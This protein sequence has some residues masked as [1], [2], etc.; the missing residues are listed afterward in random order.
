MIWR[1]A[2][3]LSRLDPKAEYLQALAGLPSYL[4]SKPCAQW[5][6]MESQQREIRKAPSISGLILT[7]QRGC[8][9]FVTRVT[10]KS[11]N[12]CY[13]IALHKTFNSSESHHF[14]SHCI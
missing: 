10:N 7:D 5:D 4:Q 13:L 9:L 2:N 12:Q 6:H 14:L 11:F 8:Q 3:P 1:K